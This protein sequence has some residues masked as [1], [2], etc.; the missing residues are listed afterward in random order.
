MRDRGG[1]DPDFVTLDSKHPRPG[2]CCRCVSKPDRRFLRVRDEL[3]LDQFRCSALACRVPTNSLRVRV[4]PG[5]ST[6]DPDSQSGDQKTI[7]AP[8]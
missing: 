1:R 2:D 4:G 3:A 7:F 8:S 6:P 5:L